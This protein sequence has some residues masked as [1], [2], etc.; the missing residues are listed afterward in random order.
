MFVL[1]KCVE[2]SGS[3][4]FSI[5]KERW[6]DSCK[7]EAI[8]FYLV[9]SKPTKASHWDSVSRNQQKIKLNLK[10]SVFILFLYS[11]NIQFVAPLNICFSVHFKSFENS[12]WLFPCKEKGGAGEDNVLQVTSRCHL[13]WDIKMIKSCALGRSWCW[14]SSLASRT[15]VMVETVSQIALTTQGARHWPSLVLSNCEIK[16]TPLRRTDKAGLLSKDQSV[17]LDFRSK[18]LCLMCVSYFMTLDSVFSFVCGEHL[19][20]HCSTLCSG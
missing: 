8:L 10:W 12:S 9:N 20:F 7:F 14:H 19:D 5:W 15:L 1:K 4:P 17:S 13:I 3:C 6:E 16:R 2:H 18:V 11:E